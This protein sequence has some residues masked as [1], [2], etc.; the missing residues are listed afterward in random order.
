[1]PVA[2]DQPE[3]RLEPDQ[4]LRVARAE[5][6][7]VGLGPDGDRR[8]PEG[9]GGTGPAARPARRQAHVVR[10]EDLAAERGVPAGHLLGHEVGQLGEVGL[11]QNH[12]AGLAQPGHQ[13]GVPVRAPSAPAPATHPSWAGR[14]RRC[15]PSPA[16]VR[17]AAG[18]GPGRPGARR[19]PAR[20][21]RRRPAQGSGA[22]ARPGR[23]GRARRSAPGSPR[24]GRPLLVAP[25][26]MAACTSATPAVSRSRSVMARQRRARVASCSQP[27]VS[28]V[29]RRSRLRESPDSPGPAGGG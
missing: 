6:R 8:Q 21:A 10:V 23:A 16:P 17:R 26:A 22:R 24:P 27:G 13:G 20:P 2:A 28:W 5:D 1:M 18:R 14:R 7:A 3:G 15:C 9:S 25:A 29:T 4:A 12:G 11:A 19:R